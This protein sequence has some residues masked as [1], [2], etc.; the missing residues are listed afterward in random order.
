MYYNT[1]CLMPPRMLQQY[2][3]SDRTEAI[4]QLIIACDV[5]QIVPIANRQTNASL[6]GVLGSLWD[7]IE[8]HTDI[9]EQY[10]LEYIHKME[11]IYHEG[12]H[13]VLSDCY[14]QVAG[15]YT[16]HEQYTQVQTYY[17]IYFHLDPNVKG[18]NMHNRYCVLFHASSMC[19]LCSLVCTY[20]LY[21]IV[22]NVSGFELR[23]LACIILQLE[24][25]TITSASSTS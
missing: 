5:I 15:F 10:Y 23:C 2:I 12:K 6:Y 7:L 1:R 20:R 17:E 24:E 9:A 25:A 18:Y 22:P 14:S 4:R 19:T 11:E 16:K 3:H 13:L 8:N 21:I